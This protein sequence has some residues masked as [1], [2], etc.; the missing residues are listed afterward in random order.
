MTV[1]DDDGG[2]GSDTALLTVGNVDPTIDDVQVYAAADITLR[3]AGEKFHDVC[4]E[5][6]HNGAVTGSAC[7]VRMPG[8]PDRQTATISGGKIPLL[9]SFA[10]TLYYTPDDDPVNGQRNGDN[11]AWV[12]LTFADGSEVRLHHNFNVQHPGTW[13]W[14]LDDLSVELVGRPITFEATASD[15]GSDDLRFDFDFGDL[16]TAST[17]VFNDGTGPDPVRS[18]DLLPLTATA[19][20]THAYSAAGTYTFTLFVSDDDGG[21]TSVSRTFTVG[22]S[23]GSGGP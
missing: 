14:T 2:C 23:G 21:S 11:P 15:V 10:I 18:P 9:G 5:M 1:C 16:A 7:V 22:A 3:V 13:V 8:S 12:I 17:T 4:L 6:A 19:S 20:T